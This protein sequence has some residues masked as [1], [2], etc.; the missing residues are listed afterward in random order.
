MYQTLTIKA[1]ISRRSPAIVIC[2]LLTLS[3]SYYLCNDMLPTMIT[4]GDV[5]A[6]SPESFLCFV[7]HFRLQ[8]KWGG[9]RWGPQG[10]EVELQSHLS[11]SGRHTFKI[12]PHVISPAHL[13]ELNST[14]PM[15]PSLLCRIL[16]SSLLHSLLDTKL[17]KIRLCYIFFIL[18]ALTFIDLWIVKEWILNFGSENNIQVQ[19]SVKWSQRKADKSTH[20]LHLWYGLG[21]ICLSD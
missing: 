18:S 12:L 20:K 5:F 2:S 1:L 7:L 19:R 3:V 17:F 14:V 4:L 8:C 9:Q 21:S 10:A 16:W 15:T 13:T 11:S 6:F